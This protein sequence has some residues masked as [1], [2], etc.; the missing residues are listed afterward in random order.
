MILGI[1]GSK[2]FENRIKIK[3][4]I[5]RL[6]EHTK[7]PITIVGLGD[8]NGADKYVKKFA[9]ELGY[10]YRE[11]NPAHTT[12][13][14]YSLMTEAYY[15]KPYQARNFHQQGQ[16]FTSYIDQCVIFDDSNQQDKKVSNLIKQLNKATKKAVIITP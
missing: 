11:M 10:E 3:N 5:H 7:E 14:L 6:K 1:T 4:F 16:I 15:S 8:K 9:L 2:T 12:K 13:T